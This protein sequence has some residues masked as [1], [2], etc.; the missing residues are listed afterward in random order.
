[1][2]FS[3]APAGSQ[4]HAR[5][6]RP[7]VADLEGENPWTLLARKHWLKANAGAKVRV[8]SNVIKIEIW[9]VLESEVFTFRSLLI[10]ENL[11][12]LEEYGLSTKFRVRTKQTNIGQLSLARL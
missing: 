4:Q 6:D 11:Q 5:N 2:A 12:I 10:L 7:V 1:M 9:D 3:D 8:K